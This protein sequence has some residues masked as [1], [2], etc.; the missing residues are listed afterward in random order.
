MRGRVN[1]ARRDKPKREKRKEK[2]ERAPR[3]NN[4]LPVSMVQRG[5]TTRK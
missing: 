5:P 3:K 1:M 2:Q 4:D